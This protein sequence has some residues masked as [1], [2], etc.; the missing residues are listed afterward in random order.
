MHSQTDCPYNNNKDNHMEEEEPLA[1]QSLMEEQAN[2]INDKKAV[3]WLRFAPTTSQLSTGV[4]HTT[5]SLYEEHQEATRNIS[6]HKKIFQ[7]KS[8]T[9]YKNDPNSLFINSSNHK[10]HAYQ[11]FIP[12]QVP[13]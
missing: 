13:T 9:L 5:S 12:N 11:T 10:A 7:K 1:S 8:R 6:S 3:E 4:F 2:E